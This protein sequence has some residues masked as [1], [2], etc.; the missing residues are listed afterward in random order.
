MKKIIAI[1]LCFLLLSACAPA[2]NGEDIK[3]NEELTESTDDAV[4]TGG[5]M[6]MVN[7]ISSYDSA[8][9][10]ESVTG[11]FLNIPE[12]AENTAFSTITGTIAQAKFTL[13]GIDYTLRASKQAPTA[14]LHGIYAEAVSTEG[15][16]T[17]G[18]LTVTAT[19]L[20]NEYSVCEWESDGA[21]YS[22][23]RDG[24]ED[25]SMVVEMITGE[26]N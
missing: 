19:N 16:A 13:D 23:S 8:E 22:L 12:R 21:F 10:V 15:F 25:M 24:V 14:A 18:G 26:I 3:M 17:T 5:M 11:I 7:P 2:E 6:G 1:I 9:E 20:G 4:S